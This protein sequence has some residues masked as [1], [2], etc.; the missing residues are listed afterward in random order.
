MMQPYLRVAALV[1]YRRLGNREDS[2]AV[3]P[4]VPFCSFETLGC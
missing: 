2:G 1:G 4:Y 3:E